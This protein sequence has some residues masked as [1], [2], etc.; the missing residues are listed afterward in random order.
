MGALHAGRQ[1][2]SVLAKP[3]VGRFAQ[4]V[5]VCTGVGESLCGNCQSYLFLLPFLHVETLLHPRL[6]RFDT[7]ARVLDGLAKMDDLAYLNEVSLVALDSASGEDI[8][9]GFEHT[10]NE[11]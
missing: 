2:V 10:E 9:G 5:E 6:E 11:K 7:S 4:L 1:G 8:E 3:Q